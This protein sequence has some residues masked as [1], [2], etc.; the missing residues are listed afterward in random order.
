MKDNSLNIKEFSFVEL[1]LNELVDFL[2]EIP[3]KSSPGVSKLPAIIIN[4]SVNILGPVILNIFNSCL[5]QCKIP[6]IF[7]FAEVLQ[8]CRYK[9]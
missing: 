6:D 9:L 7:K 5:H 2:K 3:T 4:D 8:I 1:K